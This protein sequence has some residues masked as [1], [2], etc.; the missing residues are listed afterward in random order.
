MEA[1]GTQTV[2]PLARS[3]AGLDKNGHKITTVPG[4]WEANLIASAQNPVTL[5]AWMGWAIMH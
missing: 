1:S 4:I 5:E 2:A 3:G